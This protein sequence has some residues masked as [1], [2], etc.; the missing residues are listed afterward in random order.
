MSGMF[1]SLN[2][3]TK[4]LMA[5]QTALH[6]TGHNI[7]NVNTEGYTRQRV[8]MQADKAFNFAG[9]GQLGTGVKMAGIV[10]M[11]DNHVSKQIRDENS[12]LNR[13][14]EKSNVTSHLEVIFNEPSDT[15]LDFNISEM[16]K[17]LENL[18]GNPENINFKTVAVEKLKT[19][20]DNLNHTAGKIEGLEKETHD[21]ID[22]NVLDFN[23]KVEQVNVLNK[24]IFNI[25]IKGQSPNDLLDQRDLM[26]KEISAIADIKVDIDEYGRAGITMTNEVTGSPAITE[27]RAILTKDG[28]QK[29]LGYDKGDATNPNLNRKIKL[30]DTKETAKNEDGTGEGL[31]ITNGRILGNMDALK[32][33]KESKDNL[34]DLA[35]TLGQAMNSVHKNGKGVDIF[36]GNEGDKFTAK[37][38]KVTEALQ[39][40]P[41]DLAKGKDKDGNDLAPGNNDLANDLA[42][43]AGKKYITDKDGNIKDDDNG[44]TIG[45]KFRDM[46]IKIGISKQHSDNMI[47]NQAALT[48]QLEMRRESVS[49]VSLNDEMTN[50]IK[51]Q[52]SFEANA[53][54]ITVLTE[55]LDT[56]INRTGV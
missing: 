5:S 25:T 17:A 30:Y 8:D 27:S 41:S 4:G 36:T 43:I 20:T 21:L 13:F 49:G 1:S 29:F 38:I 56:L 26:L 9:V 40:D 15:G 46:V 23:S 44:N 55:M 50:A 3:A 37:N 24:Q 18:T 14:L 28:T 35:N 51:F 6:T 34:D 2:T 22:Q 11:I 48:N 10:R 16:F 32:D 42:L 33:V 19:L 12:T 52:K 54:V 45:G 39:K 47:D 53:R 7:T 31:D